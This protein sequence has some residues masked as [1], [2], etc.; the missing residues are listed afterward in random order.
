M[1]LLLDFF[2]L[3]CEV[4]SLQQLEVKIKFSPLLSAST[5]AD[6]APFS[7]ASPR[8]PVPGCIPAFLSLHPGAGNGTRGQPEPFLSAVRPQVQSG[9][10]NLAFFAGCTC[11]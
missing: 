6:V 8:G 9:M 3:L 5:A 4:S 1:H 10:G 7:T 2:F 11:S